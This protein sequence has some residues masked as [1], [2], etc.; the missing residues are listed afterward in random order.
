M[1]IQGLIIVTV[2]ITDG[3]IM[4]KQWIKTKCN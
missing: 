1:I 4:N 2:W 3:N